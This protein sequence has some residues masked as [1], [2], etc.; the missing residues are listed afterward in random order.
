M[1]VV[2]AELT[3]REAE[4]LAL[5]RQRLS[6]GEIAE[7]L[8]VSVRTVES[9]VSA[10]LRKL[11]AEDRRALARLAGPA[12]PVG[13]HPPQPS[14][15]PTPLTPFVGRVHEL[16]ALAAAVGRDRLVTATGPGGVG[17]TRLA[18]AVAHRLAAEHRDGAVFVDLVAV[19]DP[20]LVTA[21]VADAVG[22]PERAGA[23]R[24]QAL[25]AA[26]GGRELLLV[27]DNCEH[28]LDGVRACVERILTACPSVR[29]LATSRIRLML[30]FERVFA[31]PGLSTG[32]S[33]DGAD[34][35]DAVA[36]FT[37]RMSAA[38]AAEPA[39][40]RER[41]TVRGICRALDGMALAI[42]LAAAR[43][44]GLGLDGLSGALDAHLPLLSVR[45]RGDGR[46]R[47]L[48]A[49]IDWSYALLT[50]DEREALRAAAVFAARF[51]ADALAAVTG[52]PRADV[53]DALGRLA[54]WNLVSVRAGSPT[55]YRVL[56]TIRQYAA[57]LHRDNDNDND[58]DGDEGVRLRAAHLGWVRE[59]LSALMRAVREGD[60]RDE[61]AWCAAVDAVLDDARAAMSWA[62]ADPSRHPAAVELADLL[63][64]VSYQRGH[65]GEAQ[66]SHEWAAALA[67]T[68]AERHHRLRL[69]AGAAAT[70]NVGEEAVALLERA[71]GVTDDPD[72]AACDLATAAMYP[73]RCSGIMGGAVPADL[74]PGLLERA[75]RTS[76]GG[77]AASA[78][79]AMAEGWAP[80]ATAHSRA[81]TD[82]A[83][84]LA[85]AAGDP[86]LRNMVLDQLIV[87]ELADRDLAAAL[88]ALR[89]R[90]ELLAP[91]PVDALT[92]FEFYDATH[93]ACH[94]NLAVGDLP[95]AR[96]YADAVA[97][98]PFYREERH[99]GLGRR[100]EV[101][102]MAGDFAGALARGRSMERDWARAGRPVA[103]NLAVGAYC[104]A[105]AHAVLGDA[106]QHR[107]WVAITD[108]LL[109][110]SNTGAGRDGGWRPT[111][112]ALADLHAGR[113]EAATQRLSADLVGDH[114][115]NANSILWLPWYAALW[116]ESAVLAGRPDALDRVEPAAHAARA[117]PVALAIIERAAAIAA[118]DPSRLPALVGRFA[119]AG[120]PYQAART[121]LL[122]RSAAR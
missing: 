37:A 35:G 79:I 73:L 13:T 109:G 46:H 39:T 116:V 45:G 75:R 72:L 15:L 4:V 110:T 28:L 31:V 120:C 42:E 80:G 88:A 6:N 105:T 59:R 19:V 41:A 95:A 77:P 65:P 121:T 112:D 91:L 27:V 38:G 104:V 122:A 7:Q 84:A 62:G 96:R 12:P 11:G 9:H 98:L 36:L 56:E 63:G 67:G 17:K 102:T 66:R 10:L 60:A 115:D 68:A 5:L 83:L 55:R 64:A 58:S 48:R 69:A 23:S 51:D 54:D 16:D 44:P 74:A 71:A 2:G 20:T 101:D 24:E 70:R 92:G 32:G 117:N 99:I 87:V 57:E 103:S 85:E 14:P 43:V 111:L 30:A 118:G 107:H 25:L 61:D 40:A 81:H 119:D 93:M 114:W 47:S 78:T 49:A 53:L 26:L 97:A 106:D 34:G 18:L 3:A 94:L 100:A 8:V 90:L 29:V 33:D 21:A 50:D 52:R 89:A 82:A 22:V 108:G 76:R 113:P 86:L 1:G